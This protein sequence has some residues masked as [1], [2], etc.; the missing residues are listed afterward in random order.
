MKKMYCRTGVPEFNEAIRKLDFHLQISN[1]SYATR[2]N[3]TR[4]LAKFAQTMGKLPESCTQDEILSYFMYMR[5]SG[6]TQ[7]ASLKMSIFGIKYYMK[8]IVDRMDLFSRVPLPN[9]SKRYDF[10]LL[11][12]DDINKMIQVCEDSREELILKMLYETGMRI[13]ELAALKPENIDQHN[14]VISVVWSKN[15]TTRTINFGSK[16]NNCITRYLQEYPSLFSGT[17]LQNKYHPFL[18]LSKTGIQWTLNKLARKADI[19][20]NVNAHAFRHAF[21]VH[22][23]NYGGTL[24]QLQRLLGHRSMS[25]TIVYLRYA[26]LPESMHVSVLDKTCSIQS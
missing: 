12:P 21:A 6:P 23:I 22:Y 15:K 14:R 8:H 25:T 3:Y 9:L 20:K 13:S 19:R 26:V 1:R 5:E 2:R 16:L 10:D 11:Q 17:I 24:Y 4:H 18:A 7:T